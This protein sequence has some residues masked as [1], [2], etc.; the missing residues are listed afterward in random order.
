MALRNTRKSLLA[1]TIPKSLE[2]DTLSVIQNHF[3]PTYK[4]SLVGILYRSY[5]N[6]F[7][8]SHITDI[9]VFDVG[10]VSLYHESVIQGF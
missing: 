4:L 6:S 3:V 10:L 1:Q 5:C 2:Q 7:F 8:F 9:T